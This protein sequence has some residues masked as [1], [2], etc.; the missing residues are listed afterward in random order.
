MTNTGKLIIVQK[1]NNVTII[2]I[3]LVKPYIFVC[4]YVFNLQPSVPSYIR[5]VEIIY[6]GFS[7]GFTNLVKCKSDQE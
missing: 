6:Y 1:R 7:K 2:P 4:E 5:T 3:T